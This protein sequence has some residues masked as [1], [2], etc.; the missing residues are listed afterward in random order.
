MYEETIKQQFQ[1]LKQIIQYEETADLQVD[2]SE[3]ETLIFTE[4]P[5]TLEKNAPPNF[6]ELYF[7]FKQEYERFKEFILYEK[8]IG[9]NVVALGGGFSSGK[10][11]FLNSLLDQEILPSDIRPST[12][13]PAYLVHGSDVEVHGINTFQSR[14]QMQ[15]EDVML[16]SHGFGKDDTDGTEVTLGHLLSSL[17]ISTPM[18]PFAH[19]AL[20]DTPGYSKADTAGYSAKTDEKIAR[21]QLNSSNFILWFVQAEAGTITESDIAFI[22]TLK[23]EIP[24]L[25]IVNKADKVFPDELDEIIEKI[26]DVLNLKGI[27]YLDVLAYS[28][29]EPDD[30]DKDKILAYLHQWDD[31]VTESRF[32]YNFKVLF[33]KCKEYYDELLDE[34]KKQHSRL[35][36][37]LAD[38]SLEN[39]DARDYLNSMDNAAKRQISDLKELKEQLHQLQ[40]QFF[41]EIKRIGDAVSIEMPE[42]SE[43]DLLSDR[44]TDPK[45][46]LDTYCAKHGMDTP[47]HKNLCSDFAMLLTERFTDLQPVFNSISGTM[48]YQSELAEMLEDMTKIDRNKVHLHDC[49]E[50]HA[51]MIYAT[52]GGN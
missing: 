50:L 11:S 45:A 31:S 37:I 12:S 6:P 49:M 30:Y 35:S 1:L 42:P 38:V 14:V 32:A 5:E 13:V 19:I 34:E 7:D 43:I 24:K 26:R 8:L 47:K 20:L 36:H 52:L 22:K 44:I 15:L 51:D 18:Q 27:R 9:K 17:F 48:A 39:D 25:I 3:I 16:L 2:L 29:E 21:T 23:P 28:S 33:T 40:D 46:V 41:T 4:L 10:S